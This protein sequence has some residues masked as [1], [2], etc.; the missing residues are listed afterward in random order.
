MGVIDGDFEA[1]AVAQT[2][3]GRVGLPEDIARV[4]VFLAS[5]DAGWVNG[6]TIIAAGGMR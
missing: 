5:S 2:P 1:M 6:E 4:A 3:L